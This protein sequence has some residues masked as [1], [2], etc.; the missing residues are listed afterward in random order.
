MTFTYNDKEYKYPDRLGEITL[1]QRLEYQRV[2][3]DDL[4]KRYKEIYAMED[5][6]GKDNAI[7]LQFLDA[8]VKSFS[9]FTGISL[10]ECSNNI[11]CKQIANIYDTCLTGLLK[12]QEEQ[13]PLTEFTIGDE[14]WKLA[15]PEVTYS[16][17]FTV[18]ELVQ[19]NEIDRQLK[20][21]GKGVYA[22]LPFLC[23]VFLRKEG[24]PFDEKLLDAGGERMRIMLDLPL[25]TALNVAFFL[26]NSIAISMSILPALNQ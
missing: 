7:N 19:A 3:G 5:G 1:G 6:E 10:D 18:N 13:E 17:E 11:P 9:F 14:K 16:S 12:E 15:V 8:A 21:L 2:Y 4:D 25:D 20:E 22:S 23:C 26:Q 24:E